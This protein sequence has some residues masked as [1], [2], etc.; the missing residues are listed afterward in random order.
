MQEIGIGS[1][2]HAELFV[3]DHYEAADWYEKTLGLRIGLR[4][5]VIL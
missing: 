4:N 3:P 2:D 1:I 5:A